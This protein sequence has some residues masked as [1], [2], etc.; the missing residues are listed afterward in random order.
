MTSPM[1]VSKVAGKVSPAFL[2]ELAC[3]AVHFM[4]DEN[5]DKLVHHFERALKDMVQPSG[6]LGVRLLGGEGAGF[7]R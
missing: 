6:R 7:L 1:S 2:K 5:Q 3:R 4:L